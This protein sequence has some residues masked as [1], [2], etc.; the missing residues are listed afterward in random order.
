MTCKQAGQSAAHSTVSEMQKVPADVI[1][2]LRN[3]T[4]IADPKLQA[5]QVFT[6]RVHETRGNVTDADLE[7]F[8]SAGYTK[9][10]ILDVI[11]GAG[12]KTLSNYTNHI[13][14]TPL[15]DVFQANA[16]PPKT[17]AAA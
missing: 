7:A 13:A 17:A 6:A 15:D 8:H 11:L 3:D 1:D 9:A 4:P 14:E 5:L 10:N 12:L 2:A 16:W